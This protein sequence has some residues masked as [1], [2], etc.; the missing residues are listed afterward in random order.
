MPNN[1]NYSYKPPFLFRNPH[2]QT[3]F[4]VFFRYVHTIAYERERINTPDKDFLDLDWSRHGHKSLVVLCHGMEGNS[5]AK[6]IRAMIRHL[7]QHGYDAVVYNLRGCSGTPNRLL[8]AYHSGETGDLDLVLRH[9][10]A[11]YHYEDISLIGYSL[12]GNIILKYAG[13]QGYALQGFVS[14]IAAISVPCDLESCA[15]KMNKWY[16]IIYL[17]RFLQNF[18]QKLKIKNEQFPGQFNMEALKRM[19]TFYDLDTYYTAPVHG[20]ASAQEYWQ[21]SSSKPFLSQIRVPT[22]LVNACDDTFLSDQCYPEQEIT[23]ENPYLKLLMPHYGGHVGFVQ[24]NKAGLYWHEA[25]ISDFLKA[26]V[27]A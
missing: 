16:N 11:H 13:E 25:R 21:K 4:P 20:F 23:R 17:K 6:Y 2:V 12:G 24:F 22:L 15:D 10:R 7:K 27:P 5:E 19:R 26:P 3:I 18:Y 8:R 9:I 1:P 14:S